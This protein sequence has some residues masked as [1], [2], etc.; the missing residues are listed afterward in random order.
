MEALFL[1]LIPGSFVL[2]LGIVFGLLCGSFLNVVIYRLPR[3]LSLI[4]P[5]SQCPHCGTRI[6]PYDN[7]PVFAYLWLRGRSRCCRQKISPRYPT[8]ELIGGLVGGAVVTMKL[9]P[10]AHDLSLSTALVH[11]WLYLV[12]ALGLIAAAAIDLE[13]MILPD[14]I[15][16]GGTVLG[17]LSSPLRPDV[18]PLWSAVGALCGYVGVWFPFIWLHEK[19]RGFPGMGL[20]DAKLLA[21]AGAWFGPFGALLTLFGGAIQGTIFAG[22]TLLIHGKIEEP[23]AVTEQRAEL[24]SAIEAAEGA[25]RQALLDELRADPLGVSPEEAEGGPRVAF[26]PFLALTLLELMLF[27]GPLRGLLYDYLYI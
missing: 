8:V 21:L 5:P 12:L 22:L 2:G 14:S 15:T 18:E 4:Q 19:L 17:L 10:F 13:H 9:L 6:A 11:F 27:Y 7:V 20:G 24:L 1:D 25:E 26:G 23:V 3:G 16:W